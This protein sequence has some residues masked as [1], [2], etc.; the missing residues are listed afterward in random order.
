M[1]PEAKYTVVGAVVLVLL[2]LL[3]GAVL[4]LRSTGTGPQA[5]EYRIVFEHQSLEGLTRSS[6]VTMRGMRVGAVTG[7]YFSRNKPGA[8]DVLIAV[9]PRAPVLEE[10]RATVRSNP[11]TGLATVQ[12][13]NPGAPGRPL[14]AAPGGAAPV[15]AEGEAP[16]QQI[17]AGAA[18]VVQ[19]LNAALSAQNRAAL[20]ETLD[21]VRQVSGHADRTLA[22]LDT[23]LDALTGATRRVGALASSVQA[24]AQTLTRRYDQ[25]GAQA[26]GTLGEANVAVRK[27]SADADSLLRGSEKDMQETTRSLRDAAQS[28]GLAAD[29]LREPGEILYGPG[30]GKLGPGEGAR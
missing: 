25:L 9:D 10:T 28:I 21:N 8:V 23:T 2:A 29:R 13:A 20:A 5:R 14:R 26:A 15:I 3:A 18:D 24:N 22:K 11:L 30:P 17:A 7:Y 6:D 4:W 16:E 12:L 1:E 19:R 27:A